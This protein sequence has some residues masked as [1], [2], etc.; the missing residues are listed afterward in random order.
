[1]VKEESKD[2]AVSGMVESGVNKIDMEN[3]HT[4]E[5]RSERVR[6]IEFIVC[7]ILI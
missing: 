6:G 5:K 1:M 2:G 3:V 4:K 7:F